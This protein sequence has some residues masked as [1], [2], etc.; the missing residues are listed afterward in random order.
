VRTD[1]RDV[2]VLVYYLIRPGVKEQDRKHL[3]FW[4]QYFKFQGAEMEPMKKVFG[5]K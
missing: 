5:D 4:E 3:E 2:S 1:L